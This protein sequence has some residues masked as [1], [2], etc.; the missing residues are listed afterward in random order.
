MEAKDVR[1]INFGSGRVTLPGFANVDIY[2][3][4][5][6][7]GKKQVDFVLDVEKEKLPFADDQ[8]KYILADNVFEHLGEGFIFALNEC[9]RVM[10][11][12]G[13][14]EGC[15]PFANTIPDLKDP[16][17][18]RKFI[19]ETFTY[20]CGTGEAKPDRPVHP[21]YADYKIL[22]WD[23]VDLSHDG[24]LINFRL[25]PRKFYNGKRI[26]LD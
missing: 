21:R 22:P 5:G 17:H 14:L 20:F 7:N 9:H 4:I 26:T 24:D 25:T 15:V 3:N 10:K 8:I 11:E 16:T 23:K 12:G 6:Q 18:K 19:L 1:K 2:Q 13:L